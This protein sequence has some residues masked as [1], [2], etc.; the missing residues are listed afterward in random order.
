MIKKVC[1]LMLSAIAFSWVA[2]SCTDEA[3][4][5]KTPNN[6]S[7]EE[8]EIIF[9]IKI[10]SI[11]DA[12]P[13][14]RSIDLSQ[15]NTIKTIDL[16]AFH[17]DNTGS[18]FDYYYA[19]TLDPNNTAGASTQ[20]CRV[21][22]RIATYTQE[23]VIITNGG[24]AVSD[25]VKS[26]NGQNTSKENFLAKLEY[27]LSKAGNTWN[28]V[29]ASNYDAIP[30]WGETSATVTQSTTQLSASLLRMLAKIDVQL[31]PNNLAA[32]RSVFKLKSINLYNTLT[33]GRIVPNSVNVQGDSVIA[34][35]LPAT[36]GKYVGPLLYDKSSDFSAPGVV[37]VAMKGAIYLFETQA[38]NISEPF[39]P[40]DATCVI[41]GGLYDTDT[42]QSYYRVDFL[43]NGK[44]QDILR[45]HR[46]LVNI[47]SVTG[48]GYSTVDEAYRN[49]AVN[50]NVN[51]IV[52]NDSNTYNV[53]LK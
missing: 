7:G 42:A 20:N 17:K 33:N 26:N 11:N 25:L 35:T 52:W 1:K 29:S 27:S 36:P 28:A 24:T 45:N 47:T 23:L 48:R 14:F 50:M 31:D 10:P 30:M 53:D 16:V 18:Y 3:N 12:T 49:K 4:N 15:E 34:P 46:Y 5:G 13:Q 37:D 21:K 43:K 9:S 6:F 51:I 32:L 2:F 41:V 8:K 22:V 19:G 44:F 40:L 39:S 38:P